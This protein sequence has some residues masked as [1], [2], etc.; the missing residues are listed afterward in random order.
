[1][2]DEHL[3]ELAEKVVNLILENEELTRRLCCGGSV[4]PKQTCP[5]NHSCHADFKCTKPFKCSNVHDIVKGS[6]GVM[7]G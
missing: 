5:K 7:E 1:V 6:G 2:E 4:L 3:Q